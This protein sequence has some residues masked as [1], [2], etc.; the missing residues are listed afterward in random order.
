MCKGKLADKIKKELLTWCAT[1]GYDIVLPNFYVDGYEM[2]VFKLT[3][4]DICVEYEIKVSR[5]DFKKNFKKNF[6]SFF[7]NELI[8]K[9]DKIKK[10]TRLCNRFYFVVPEGLINISEIPEYCGLIYYNEERNKLTSIRGA[11]MLHKNKLPYD[12]Y[13]KL[14]R[15][16]AWRDSIWKSKVR[17]LEYKLSDLNKEI[18]KL[19][20]IIESLKKQ[21]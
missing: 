11:K 2:D 21:Y 1:A 3:A 13:K 4:S 17:W 14:A 10:G 19:T 9:H 7:D 20:E 6:K 5:A 8:N 12:Y 18:T 16:L 15:Q